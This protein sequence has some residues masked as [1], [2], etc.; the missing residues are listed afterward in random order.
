MEKQLEEADETGVYQVSKRGKR[1][2]LMQY[3]V[4]EGRTYRKRKEMAKCMAENQGAGPRKE[5]EEEQMKDI[6]EVKEWEIK[7]VARRSPASSANGANDVPLRMVLTVN[8][9]HPES[10]REI[11][12]N[13]LRRGKHPEIWKDVDLVPIPK[14]KKKTYMSPKSWR[15]IHLLRVVSKPLERIVLRCLQNTEGDE[16]RELG[17]TQFGSRRN[18][19]TTDAMTAFMRWKQETR[20][21]GHY[22]SVVV[23][24]IEVGFDKVDPSTLQDSPLDQNYIPWI[25]SWVRNRRMRIRINGST[26]EQIYTTNQGIPQGSP[27]SPNLFC[28]HIKKVMGSRITD[29]GHSM[30]MVISYVEDAVICVSAKDRASLEEKAR[31]IWRNMR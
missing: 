30:K 3:L 17:K 25:K 22:Q 26:D 18:R 15:P 9:A 27:L 6:E 19:G 21:R 5:E 23:A 14:A 1:K 12:M 13:I 24:D 29:D 7:D 4:Q 11:F 20:R 16:G 10:L 28:A 31:E 8:Q 2:K